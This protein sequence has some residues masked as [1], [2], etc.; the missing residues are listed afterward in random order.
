[1]SGKTMSERQR[2]AHEILDALILDGE[3]VGTLVRT[4]DQL[5]LLFTPWYWNDPTFASMASRDDFVYLGHPGWY[6]H[7]SVKSRRDLVMAIVPTD[8]LPAGPNE[9]TELYAEDGIEF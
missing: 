3:I 5:V 7:M 6:Y 9:Y 8:M 1:M 2:E 4:N